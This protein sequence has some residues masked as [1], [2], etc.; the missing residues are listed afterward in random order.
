[1]NK[2]M[3]ANFQGTE[4]LG[5]QLD[6]AVFVVLKPLVEAMGLAWHG[7]LERI[8]RDEVLYEG[9]RI[10]RIPSIEGGEQDTVTLRLNRL[11]GWLFTIE[12][13]RLRE[14]IQDRVRAFQRECYEVLYDHFYGKPE[15]IRL[16]GN[17]VNVTSLN[18]RLCTE[19]R[20]IH[21]L[22]AAA[23][24]WQKLGLPKVPAMDDVLRQYSLFEQNEDEDKKAA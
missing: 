21:G 17:D 16:E 10:M 8:K 11:H 5:V 7:Q 9:I 22:R 18:L 14:E 12:V 1:M 6:G 19:S 24:L 3:T 15:Q 2:M 13:S 4:I 20:H 23:Q